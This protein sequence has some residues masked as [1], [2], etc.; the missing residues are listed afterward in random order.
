M[1]MWF[2]RYC[3]KNF[4]NMTL[5]LVGGFKVVLDAVQFFIYQ[6]K[7]TFNCYKEVINSYDSTTKLPF[8]N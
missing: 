3:S 2:E 5:Q 7:S 1:V 6:L 8:L 4:I